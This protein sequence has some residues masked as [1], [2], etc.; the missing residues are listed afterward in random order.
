MLENPVSALPASAT[1]RVSGKPYFLYVLWSQLARRFYTG[2]AQDPQ[3]RLA[4]H[5]QGLSGWTSRYRPWELVH[6]E[7]HNNYRA[8]RKRE[9][10]L[11][12]QKAGRGFFRLTGLEPARFRS[13][14]SH[15]S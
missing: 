3:Q 7:L 11:K 15:G 14:R 12:A 1:S 9:L 8:A 4:Q 5:N 6:L 2:I 13:R 10:E